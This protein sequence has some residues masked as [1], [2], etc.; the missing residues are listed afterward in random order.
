MNGVSE[1]NRAYIC[2]G[3]TFVICSF[4]LWTQGLRSQNIRPAR[5]R[6]A[7]GVVLFW[8]AE[9]ADAVRRG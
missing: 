2:M 4:L 7:S 9:S 8:E 5:R 6:P 3:R 1:S